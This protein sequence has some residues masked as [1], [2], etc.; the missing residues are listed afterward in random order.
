MKKTMSKNFE[1]FLPS[2]FPPY[3]ETH[4]TSTPH[5]HKRHKCEK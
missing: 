3:T 4:C 1:I 2:A 5:K